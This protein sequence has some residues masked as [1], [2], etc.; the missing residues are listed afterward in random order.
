[1][2]TSSQPMVP[3]VSLPQAVVQVPVALIPVVVDVVMRNL[4]FQTGLTQMMRRIQSRVTVVVAVV[5]DHKTSQ[6]DSLVAP[7]VLLVAMVVAFRDD[8]PL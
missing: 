2:V 4:N 8:Q 1:M 6:I 7:A 3:D 5:C